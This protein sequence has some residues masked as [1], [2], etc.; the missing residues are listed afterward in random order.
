MQGASRVVVS[1]VPQT[2]RWVAR[3]AGT[4]FPVLRDAI[5]IGV[6]WAQA[7]KAEKRN[8]IPEVFGGRNQEGLRIDAV[9]GE[10]MSGRPRA[11]AWDVVEE[12]EFIACS[13]E[14]QGLTPFSGHSALISWAL[15][16]QGG[17]AHLDPHL[18]CP[19]MGGKVGAADRWFWGVVPNPGV[20]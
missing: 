6:I 4:S 3:E 16:E 8:F 1:G 10:G 5:W 18:R 20:S 14:V 11:S 19:S 17:V 12:A 13:W 15:W 7:V 2:A 9:R